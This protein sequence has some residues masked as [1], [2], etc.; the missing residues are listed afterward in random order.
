MKESSKERQ[1]VNGKL[2]AVI[3]L[4]LV[5]NNSKFLQCGMDLI[6]GQPILFNLDWDQQNR[7][8][9]KKLELSCTCIH[10]QKI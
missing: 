6:K 3:E 7:Y 10:L 4:G 5:A 2:E 9:K 1:Q 8:L